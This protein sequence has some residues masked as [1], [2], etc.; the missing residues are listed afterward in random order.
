LG[1]LRRRRQPLH[2]RLARAGG[3][4]SALDGTAPPGLAA[5]TPGWDGIQ[6]GEPGIHGVPRARLWDAVATVSIAGLHGD[7]I[8]FVAVGDGQLVGAA[9]QPEQGRRALAAAV[10]QSLAPPYR[11]EAVRRGADSW[12]VGASRIRTA[13]IPGLSGNEVELVLG[14]DGPVLHI[15][16][17]TTLQRSALLEQ[18]GAEL[19]PERVLRAWRLLGELWEVEATPL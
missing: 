1:L 3:L 9:D 16:G 2:E 6:R 7:D 11:A 8:S 5:E 13:R 4:E 14:L 12:A 18:I 19:G 17:R 15:D 10:E